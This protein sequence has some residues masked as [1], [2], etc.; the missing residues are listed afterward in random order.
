MLCFAPI[1][2]LGF[3]TTIETSWH[4]T[5]N[6]DGTV[7]E[8]QTCDK[9]IGIDVKLSMSGLYGI[10]VQYGLQ[11]DVGNGVTIALL[12]KAGA[13]YV[14]HPN[15]ALPSRTQFEVG[16]QLLVGYGRYRFGVEY[17]H[18]SNAG[19]EYPNVGQDMVIFQT[20]FKFNL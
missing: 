16:A 1:V 7:I 8:I 15:E 19:M 2:L 20:G 9:G 3:A 13:S 12:P 5:P 17:W 6:E 14:D 10:A 18:M 4:K 11:K